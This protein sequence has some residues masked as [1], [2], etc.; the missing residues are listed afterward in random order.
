MH[1][2]LL[3]SLEHEGHFVHTLFLE[4][5]S[6]PHP[7]LRIGRIH[8]AEDTW[9]AT[10]QDFPSICPQLGEWE[11][12]RNM[13]KMKHNYFKVPKTINSQ[14]RTLLKRDILFVN[15]TWSLDWGHLFPLQM[16]GQESSLKG[17]QVFKRE[18]MARVGRRTAWREKCET[19][20]TW[21]LPPYLL[22]PHSR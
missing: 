1:I 21:D 5:T 8:S 9:V 7:G 15:Y 2:V 14:F 4:G 22:N 19:Q 3:H 6:C 17:V 13:E 20:Q 10:K 12:I 18:G 11:Q 16:Q